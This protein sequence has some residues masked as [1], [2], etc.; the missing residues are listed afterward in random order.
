MKKLNRFIF[1]GLLSVVTSCIYAQE[2]SKM[3]Y[4]TMDT[5]DA[6]HLK[7]N[8]PDDVKIIKSVNDYTAVML[9]HHSAEELHHTGLR[10][11][12]GYFYETSREDAINA[13]KQVNS[14]QQLKSKSLAKMAVAFE[15]TQDQLVKQSLDLVNN[16]N[17]DKQIKE[18]ESYGTRYHTK[19]SA[20]KASR[21]LK[22]KWE[23]LAGN[24]S[25]VSVRLVNHSGTSMPSVVMTVTGT[26]KP[27]EYVV[28]GGHLDSTSREGQDNAP[29][30]DDNASGIATI[31]E[32]A[33]VLFSMNFKPKRTVEFMA[34]AAE[35]IG[36]VGSKEIARDYK[37]RN[38]NIV[39]YM[40][41]D[42]TNYKGSTEDVFITTDS[43][44]STSL[45]NFLR[46]LMDHYNASGKHKITYNNSACNYGCSDHHSFAQQGYETAFP[47]E[48][49]FSESNPNIHT[50]RDTSSRFPTS[51][52]THAAKFAKLALEY[53]IEISNGVSGGDPTPTTYC[54]S[55][56][57]NTS[58]EYISK[59][60][61]GTINKTSVAGSGGYSDF[62]AESTNLSTGNN[63]IT[64]TPKWTGTTYNEG[65]A[66]WIDYN[67]DNDFLDS[68]E[69]VWSKGAS[70]T[71]PASGSFTVPSGA[72]S[73]KTRMRVSM[74]Y[75]GIPTACESF[76]YGEV[77]DYSV[78]IGD[79]GNGGDTQ[80]PSVPT[81]VSASN[82]TETTLTVSWTAATDN[83]GVTEYDVYQGATKITS[84]TRT[85]ANVTGL[86]A[87][88]TYQFSV[89]AKDAA[90]NVSDASAVVSVTTTGSS[91]PCAGVAPYDGTKTYQ[92]GDR[93]TY[94]GRLYER[95]SGDWKLIGSCGGFARST[96][97]EKTLVDDTLLFEFYPNPVAGDY[98]NVTINNNL[99]KTGSILII[100]IKGNIVQEVKLK[101]KETQINISK[102]S[103]GTYFL[104]LF[105]GS[106]SYAKQM[107]IK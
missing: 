75:N 2:K 91:D 85:T 7:E 65:Y 30:A 66:V 38:V 46:K 11:G 8:H 78:V 14:V 68:G 62:T 29:G 19:S 61:L 44:N 27:D 106:K 69:L 100:D 53:L 84:V 98:V 57:Q 56:G 51:N 21:D 70:K 104:T 15:I 20:A 6:L 81:G 54:A 5:Q 96:S 93:V 34:F 23:N 22:T 83:V 4:A 33:R 42:M 79:G 18:L 17:I 90:G 31:T 103:T 49:K 45:N 72:K 60:A 107:V 25:D 55:N 12:P 87:S 67:Q 80:A 32:V 101:N 59:V 82:I 10:H 102:F 48:A 40:Q 52:S 13:I 97:L 105:N 76:E 50:S 28:L 95:I 71:T 41:L 35:E 63:T 99:W 86:T 77:E 88:T 16:T 26:E 9:N 64:V 47:I 24:R 73:G 92:V 39:S 1:A 36:L 94:R 74:K 58:D 89:K 43:Y 3:F 37:N